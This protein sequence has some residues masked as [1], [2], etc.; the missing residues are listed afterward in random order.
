MHLVSLAA[1]D[2]ADWEHFVRLFP[3]EWHTRSLDDLKWAAY[4]MSCHV[5]S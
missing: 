1:D 5:F 4:L 2:F 3:D